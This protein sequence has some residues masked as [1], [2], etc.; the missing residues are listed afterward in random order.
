MTE[1]IVPQGLP[2]L[3]TVEKAAEIFADAGMTPSAIRATIFK[4]EDRFNSRGEKIPGNGLAASGA[5]LRRGRKILIDVEKYG[6][7][8]AGGA[9]QSVKAD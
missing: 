9:D 2:R 3:A 7:W 1:Q 8:L 4:R 6:K 5:L